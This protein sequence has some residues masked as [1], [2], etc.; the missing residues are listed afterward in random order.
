MKI[1][2]VVGARPQF[3]KSAVLSRLIEE[4]NN[5]EEIVVH[6]GQHYD[7][8]M[9]EIF[10]AELKIK[11]PKYNLGIN[12]LTR[13]EM[14]NRMEQDISSVIHIEKPDLVL[15]Y[16]DTN[17]TLAGALAAEEN[18]LS[19]AHVEAGLRSYN[20]KMP[21]ETN[22]VLTDRISEFLF[23]PTQKALDNLLGEGFDKLSKKIVLSGDIML[24]A[25]LTFANLPAHVSLPEKEFILFTLHREENLSDNDRLEEIIKQVNELTSNYI[26]YFPAHPRTKKLIDNLPFKHFIK[27]AEPQGYTEMLQLIK[28][29]KLVITDSGGL[30]KESYFFK[31]YCLVLR[32]ET[33]WNELNE[34]GYLKLWQNSEEK[35][36]ML[37]EQLMNSKNRFDENFYGDG[38]AAEKIIYTLK[39]T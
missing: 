27:I 19:L 18:K 6:T 4:E 12:Q 15:V 21:E 14:I 5:L 35:I 24:D 17:S 26:V 20:L 25:A 28:H 22:R 13:S 8:N 10:F 30:Q 33:E 31:K 38:K 29:C 9:S 32:H 3:I 7:Y 39:N 37:I 1:L 11:L 2:T 16:G 23:C 34:N 36:V